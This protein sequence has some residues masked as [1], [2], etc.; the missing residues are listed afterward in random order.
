MAKIVVEC[1][2]PNDLEAIE[3]ASEQ[4]VGRCNVTYFK[5]AQAMQKIGSAK[6][7][8]AASRK[9]AEETEET[10]AAVRQ[11]II[12]GKKEVVR[13]K[14]PEE[15]PIKSDSKGG[16]SGDKLT[17]PKI[18]KEVKKELLKTG[19]ERQ[20]A[21]IVAQKTGKPESSVRRTYQR[22]VEKAKQPVV[23]PASEPIVIPKPKP[24]TDWTC[25][26]CGTTYPIHVGECSKCKLAASLPTDKN[27]TPKRSNQKSKKIQ[28]HIPGS[29]SE[30]T[31]AMQFAVISISQLERIRSNDPKRN[32]AFDRVAL[33]ITNHK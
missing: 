4:F 2:N 15:T 25:S 27:N 10:E 29:G 20:A 18:A 23:T 19:S 12:K 14:P 9:I 30:A 16:D 31:E 22:E 17:P 24:V 11:R 13:G 21:K 33:W 5:Q 3:A 8:R 6:S 32:E 28:N 7:Q 1:T 26:T